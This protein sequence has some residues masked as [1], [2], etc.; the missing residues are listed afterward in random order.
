MTNWE[1]YSSKFN[2]TEFGLTK[3]DRP[4]L[5][6]DIR[7]NDCKWFS[8]DGECSP[9]QMEWLK[10]EFN[11]TREKMHQAKNDLMNTLTW[12]ILCDRFSFCGD[13]PLH[14]LKEKTMDNITCNTVL[15]AVLS[16]GIKEVLE[17]E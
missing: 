16:E 7:C 17:N 6:S 14:T 2:T 3:D 12:N 11:D 15:R 9:A 8:A 1:K 5:C 4:I 10:S 13:C